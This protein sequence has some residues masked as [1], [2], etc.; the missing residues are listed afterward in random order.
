MFALVAAIVSGVSSHARRTDIVIDFPINSHHIDRNFSDNTRQLQR[1]DS[2]LGPNRDKTL[3][4]DTVW[5]R[6][7]ASPDGRL[8]SNRELSLRRMVSIHDYL[9]GT[10]GLDEEKIYGMSSSVPWQTFREMLAARP[11]DGSDKALE[12]IAEGDDDNSADNTRRMNRLKRLDNGRV[13]AIL[14]RDFFPEMRAACTLVVC[15]SLPQPQTPP[16]ACDE[17]ESVTETTHTPA[18]PQPEPAATTESGPRCSGSWRLG[19]SVA[20]WAAAVANIM[21]EYDFACRWSVALAADYSG[22]NYGKTTRKYRVFRLRPEVR[23]YTMPRHQGFFVE[24]H[25]AMIYYNVALPS[26]DYRIQ[27]R[28]GRRP[29]LG[30]GIGIGYRLPLDRNGRWSLEAAVGAGAYH[31]YY[32]RFENRANGPLVDSRKRFFFGID[33]VALSITYTINP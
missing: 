1:L 4:I 2:L 26:W 19:T 22:W 21:G 16:R 8:D 6:A 11:F 20:A 24:A 15:T 14:C 23:F 30:G 5:V 27:D 25:A 9:V 3:R 31:L 13:W 10:L 28:D 17:T 7:Y 29:A 18:Q 32:D 12:I 33:N